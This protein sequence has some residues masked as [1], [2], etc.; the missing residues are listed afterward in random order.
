[1][2][3]GLGLPALLFCKNP[4]YLMDFQASGFKEKYLGAGSFI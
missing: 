4:S 3:H 2:V 1:M